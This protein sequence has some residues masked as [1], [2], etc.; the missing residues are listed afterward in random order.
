MEPDSG[1]V[2][3]GPGGT[4]AI[5]PGGADLKANGANAHPARAREDLDLLERNV[6]YGRTRQRSA[7]R[8][9]SFFVPDGKG[10][11]TLVETTPT[12]PDPQQVAQQKPTR[13]T[14][15]DLSVL[16]DADPALAAAAWE[17]IREAARRQV[18]SGHYAASSIESHEA[19]PMTRALFLE[20]REALVR[21]WAPVGAV[22]LMLIDD[23]AQAYV[24][25]QRWLAAAMS[26]QELPNLG[27][28]DRYP[29]ESLDDYKDRQ[30]LQEERRQEEE[31]YPPRI[32]TVQATDRAL[33]MAD[34]FEKAVARGIRSLRDLRRF[35][36]PMS[37]QA[38]QV[39]IANGPQQVNVNQANGAQ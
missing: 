31:Y 9:H 33:E 30:R 39:N 10:G 7:N 17:R 35:S 20:I 5:L 18:Q 8:P 34:R 23:L 25:R 37:I 32:T 36:A 1:R 6:D 38:G 2:A 16:E 24:L 3:G 27:H 22:E 13:M 15:A 26:Y 14:Y 12:S 28:K 4:A 11:R 29:D 21:Q 19:S